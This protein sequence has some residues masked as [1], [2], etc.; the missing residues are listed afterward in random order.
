MHHAV[1][2]L[3]Q[4]CGRTVLVIAPDAPEPALPSDLPVGIAR[5]AGPFGGPLAG[6]A[7][8]LR[9][10][11]TEFA[12]IAGGDM[13]EPEPAVLLEMVETGDELHAD[14]VALQDGPTF[15]PL[16]SVVRAEPARAVGTDLLE[17]GE[18]R[19]RAMLEALHVAVI[20][21]RRWLALDPGRRTL[22]DADEPSDLNG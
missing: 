12:L 9:D 21:E 4:V 13:P 1:R 14:A 2:R 19:L 18:S 22:F 8:G 15:R 16:P 3:A 6:T 5:D 11:G 17:R 10:V 7:A 20:D